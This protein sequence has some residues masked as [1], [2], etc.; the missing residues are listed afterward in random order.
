MNFCIATSF[1]ASRAG[2]KPQD[3]CSQVASFVSQIVTPFKAR[4][5]WY[6][7]AP[8][9]VSVDTHPMFWPF[10]LA[11]LLSSSAPL[12][13]NC[14]RDALESPESGRY[15]ARATG[16]AGGALGA[17]LAHEAGHVAMNFALGNT[18][19]YVGI[20]GFGFVPFF[21]ISP[22][23][24]CDLH[25]CTRRD[26]RVFASGR[27]GMYLISTAGFLVQHIGSEVI[28]SLDAHLRMHRAPVRKGI[29]AFN[30]LL[31]V[32]YGIASMAGIEEAHG[33]ARGAARMAGLSPWAFAP[34]LMAPALLD[35]YRYWVPDAAW[36][37]WLSRGSKAAMVGLAFTF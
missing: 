36:A 9:G 18:P 5:L 2:V 33:D 22:Q 7:F 28:L 32:G 24:R 13:E 8:R 25:G 21:A 11:L 10:C 29:L 15:L 31:S 3:F 20:Y 12:E 17:F 14:D 35:M 1:G 16:F 6:E 27:R 30:I 34:L 4:F 37:P 23:L 26:G 19:Q